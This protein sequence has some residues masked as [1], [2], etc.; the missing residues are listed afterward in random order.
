MVVLITTSA[1][2]RV[3]DHASPYRPL[4]KPD[5]VIL[6]NL[7]LL[8]T[9]DLGTARATGFARPRSGPRRTKVVSWNGPQRIPSVPVTAGTDARLSAA[10]PVSELVPG[11]IFRNSGIQAE[12]ENVYRVSYSYLPMFHTPVAQSEEHR[13]PKPAAEGST[14]SGRA[15]ATSLPSRTPVLAPEQDCDHGAGALEG[16][17]RD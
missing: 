3:R 1:G 10:V 14:P 6:G 4:P 8:A 16:R 13:S 12:A 2:A 5:F 11:Q 7:E 17:Q 15:A 9:V